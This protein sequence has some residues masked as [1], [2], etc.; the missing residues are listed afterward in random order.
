MI[1]PTSFAKLESSAE[2]KKIKDTHVLVLVPGSINGKDP[3][4]LEAFGKFAESRFPKL[5]QNG[6][7]YIWSKAKKLGCDG[8]SH[9]VLMTKE[10]LSESRNKRFD[11]QIKQ[12][13]D[14]GNGDYQV[15]NALDAVVCTISE[16][17]RSG[18][19]TRLFNDKPCTYTRC[20][21]NIDGYQIYVGGFALSGLHVDRN[22]G[23]D[24]DDMGVAGVRKF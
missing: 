14:K 15:P 7:R 13:Q 22:S 5:G 2:G 18:E 10:V 17:A 6:Y 4:T 23:C 24:S 20:Q 11:E 8:K 16:Y 1:K 21:E 12:I 9:W 19:T 3:L